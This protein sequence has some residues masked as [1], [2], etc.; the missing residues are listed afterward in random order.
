VARANGGEP[1]AGR[2]LKSWARQAGFDPK[3]VQ[4]TTSTW[5]FNTDAER[6]WWG[7]LW[8]ERAVKSDF[9]KVAV[10][11]GFA[12]P[13]DLRR[14]A[15]GWLDWAADVDGWLCIPHSEILCQ[16]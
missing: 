1:D 4:A 2:H 8:A 11:G 10:E 6:E 5:C 7:G 12:T 14:L 16:V 13:E 15:Q 3:R 9:A